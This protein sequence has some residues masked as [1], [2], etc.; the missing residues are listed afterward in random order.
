MNYQRRVNVSQDHSK[1]SSPKCMSEKED[2]S[3]Y[4]MI[5]D[6]SNNKLEGPW[7]ISSHGIHVPRGMEFTVMVS[8]C[9]FSSK[10]CKTEACPCGW[11][12]CLQ[13]S[14]K[15][16]SGQPP[17]KDL[18]SQTGRRTEEWN[19]GWRLGFIKLNLK[20]RLPVQQPF[21][22]HMWLLCLELCC[23][24]WDMQS[25]K[26]KPDFKHGMKKLNT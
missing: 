19:G 6:T 9:D 25:V 5:V 8:C 7:E 17:G 15:P 22:R 12:A 10:T 2:D 16:F 26:S 18:D 20:L 23:P 3:W 14:P 13:R 21:I 24:N 11:W 4:L 1:S